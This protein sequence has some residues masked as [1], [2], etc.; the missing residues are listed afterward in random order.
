M[1]KCTVMWICDQWDFSRPGYTAQRCRNRNPVKI[2]QCLSWLQIISSWYMIESLLSLIICR[3]RSGH[4]VRTVGKSQQGDGIV[5]WTA[6][7]SSKRAHTQFFKTQSPF[8]MCVHV[9]VYVC[10]Y[11]CPTVPLLGELSRER[12]GEREKRG[13]EWKWETELQVLVLMALLKI[14]AMQSLSMGQRK[15]NIRLCLSLLSLIHI[16]THAR[17]MMCKNVN[18]YIKHI[19]GRCVHFLPA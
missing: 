9:C 2:S 19:A 10:T 3:V 16:Q 11:L 13:G 18:K 12:E 4:C 6:A 1:I 17:Y 15:H 14:T 5:W 8:C 7:E